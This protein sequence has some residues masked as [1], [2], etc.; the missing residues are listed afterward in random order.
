[1]CLGYVH[2]MNVIPYARAIHGWIVV[3]VTFKEVPFPC[4]CLQEQWDDVSFRMMIFAN[5]F[6]RA[7]CVEI[8]ESDHC[9]P[10]GFCIPVEDT[11]QR[12]FALTVGIYRFLQVVFKDWGR[13]GISIHRGR[14]REH[15]LADARSPDS[16]QQRDAGGYVGI[17]KHAGIRHRLRNER[18]SC[19]VK[20]RVE[21][22]CSQH[23]GKS[24]AILDI[25]LMQDGSVGY[26]IGMA[27]RKVIHYRN[28]MPPLQKL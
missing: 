14:R 21:A 18:L 1:M 22:I 10:V 3:A 12:Q 17:E 5:A 24:S 2:D 27:G 16:L 19:E 20:D 8:A 6:R 9:P 23:L 7:A 26:G 15:E 11:L 28:P 4:S 13:L 25:Q